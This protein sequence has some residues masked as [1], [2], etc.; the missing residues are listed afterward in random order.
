MRVSFEQI[1][2]GNLYS[3]NE[4]AKLRDYSSMHAIARGV[5]TP[6]KLSE[7]PQERAKRLTIRRVIAKYMNA[8]PLSGT[9][10]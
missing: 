2:V 8:S 3:R 1:Q 5:V 6:Q 7:K 4:L 9:R 10:S